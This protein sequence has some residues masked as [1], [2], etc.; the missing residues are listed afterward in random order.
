MSD[1]K[2]IALTFDVEFWHETDWLKPYIE[3][4]MD[5]NVGFEHSIN[6][7]L[8]LLEKYGRHATFFVTEAVARSYPELIQTISQ[9]GHEIASH[10]IG[11]ARLPTRDP[12]TYGA[13]FK[14]HINSMEALIGKKVK[15]FRAP[16]FSLTDTSKWLISLLESLGFQY[17]SSVMPSA[18]AEYG[19][20]DAPRKPYLIS[21]RNVRRS[22]EAS[23]IL[24]IPVSVFGKLRIPFA[25]GIYFRLLPYPIFRFFLRRA[26][27]QTHSPV[28]Y[29]HPHELD[30]ETPRISRGPWLK[31]YIKYFGV[32]RSLQKL[33][34][35]L[36]D[37]ECDSIERIFFR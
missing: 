5:L 9:A 22:D 16:H 6:K 29:F 20:S 10:G 19:H 1:V 11:H 37:H 7:V 28:I 24:E 12:E 26:L 15:G 3:P 36:R 32:K 34:K 13:E 27:K 2:R 8:F 30:P 23:Q 35:I 4:S 33:E 18:I 17:D 31:R 25:G 21:S 14:D